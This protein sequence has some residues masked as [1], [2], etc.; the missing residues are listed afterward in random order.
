MEN[1]D[2]R[3]LSYRSK[4]STKSIIV[5]LLI[6]IGTLAIVYGYV[7]YSNLHSKLI[8]V[9]GGSSKI[10]IPIKLLP[11]KVKSLNVIQKVYRSKLSIRELV[12]RYGLSINP[13]K[14]IA[15]QKIVINRNRFIIFFI[16]QKTFNNNSIIVYS[17]NYGKIL[18]S[19]LILLKK[20]FKITNLNNSIVS[21]NIIPYGIYRIVSPGIL[22]RVVEIYNSLKAVKLFEASS[23]ELQVYI[24][25]IG[26]KTVGYYV[27][28]S[29]SYK[30]Y[31]RG[32][33]VFAV[34]ASG[35]F[36]VDPG[37][38]VSLVADYSHAIVHVPL[39]KCSFNS[40]T[41]GTSSI[42]ISV[43]ADGE[44]AL[45]DCPVTVKL[46]AWAVVTVD[47]Y[48]NVMRNSGGNK[49]IAIGCG[50]WAYPS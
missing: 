28:E 19:R 23:Y 27:R 36:Y 43:R 11:S 41:M 16:N 47:K 37:V 2:R 18:P 48:G 25:K 50:C 6:I 7:E 4:R 40:R 45:L 31:F 1:R 3:Q 34:Y 13:N 42:A 39:S 46:D 8:G 10:V 15:V 33:L 20:I 14:V 9:S 30:W 29:S 22:D 38:Y 5:T 12:I 44:A 21:V 17:L 26:Y 24:P 35:L 49:W 32:S